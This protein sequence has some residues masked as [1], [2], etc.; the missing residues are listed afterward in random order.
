[1]V[2]SVPACSGNRFQKKPAKRVSRF[3]RV[4]GT[5]SLPWSR[6]TPVGSQDG[7]G[8]DHFLRV[9]GARAKDASRFSD[10][11]KRAD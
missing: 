10:M 7:A 5:L 1:M 8:G 6:I 3:L 4:P 9:T 11:S 2:Q